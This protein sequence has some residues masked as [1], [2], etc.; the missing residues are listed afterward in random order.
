MKNILKLENLIKSGN[1]LIWLETKE[2]IRAERIIEKIA[3]DIDKSLFLYDVDKKIYSL[4]DDVSANNP[5]EFINEQDNSILIIKDLHTDIKEVKNWRA[6]ANTIPNSTQNNNSI[7][8]ISPI[9]DIPVEI[10]HYISLTK[11]SLPTREELLELL[12]DIATDNKINLTDEESKIIANT[13]IGLTEY[14]F[15]NAIYSSIVCNKNISQESIFEIK[16]QLV[17][18]NESIKIYNSNKGFDSLCGMDNM[19]NFAKSMVKSGNGRGILILGVS[20]CGKTEFAKRLGFETNRITISLDF[21]ALMGSYVGE[22]EYNTREAFNIIEAM[23]QSI[24]F[25]DEIEK[26]LSGTSN[27]N[28]SVSKRQGGQ[29]LKWMQD[30]DS[31]SY[32]VATANNIADLPS[33]YLRSGRWDAI[34]F[35]DMPSI[36]VKQQI[37]ELYKKKYNLDSEIEIDKLN[38]TGAEIETLCRLASSLNITLEEAKNFV[39]PISETNKED[40]ENLKKFAKK[41][42]VPSD[43]IKINNTNNKINRKV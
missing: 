4:N 11:L 39:C 18:K 9:V 7:I 35:V 26:S 30:H 33:E 25:I 17:E 31:D 42:A 28:D 24:V 37:L 16:K 23:N 1:P 15:K 21:G 5:L 14:E 19:K 6:L 12:C 29:F 2:Y 38:Y 22:T 3:L 13:G 20:G 40:I 43:M 8:I 36:E 10:S 41:R 32:V 34:F 27:S